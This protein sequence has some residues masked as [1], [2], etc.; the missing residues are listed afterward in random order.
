MTTIDTLIHLGA[1]LCRELD[2]HLALQPERLILV[3]A[4][5]PL[6]EALS[7]R[8]QGLERVDVR[9]ARRGGSSPAR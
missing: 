2:A 5:P 3:E 7:A 9:T 4:D 1:G 8:T 6:A